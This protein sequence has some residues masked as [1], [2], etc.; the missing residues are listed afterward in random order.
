MRHLR[1]R[2]SN[3]QIMV[4]QLEYPDGAP[5]GALQHLMAELDSQEFT[6]QQLLPTDDKVLHGLMATKGNSAEKHRIQA[7]S[8]Y[9]E[10]NVERIGGFLLSRVH[11]ALFPI[12]LAVGEMME[13]A[14][15]CWDR[16]R[17]LTG[18]YFQGI[19]KE[20]FI[21]YVIRFITLIVP[22]LTITK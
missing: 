12:D 5:V 17:L 9:D 10:A 22:L 11:T 14:T 3:Q 15:L 21:K 20:A 19:E 13:A 16:V 4:P 8:F 6:L 2:K 7:M 18:E 1:V